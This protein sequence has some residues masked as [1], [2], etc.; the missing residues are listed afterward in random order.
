MIR[1]ILRNPESLTQLL[2]VFGGFP[3]VGAFPSLFR[4]Q[5][6]NDNIIEVDYVKKLTPPFQ[7]QED[8]DDDDSHDDDSDSH[9]EE[10]DAAE[11][12][13]E[14]ANGNDKTPKQDSGD[15]DGNDKASKQDSGDGGNDNDSDYS[16]EPP[17][18]DG[19]GGGILGLLAG[20]S[21][22]VSEINKK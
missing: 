13:I 2:G 9:S 22:G 11:E 21:G 20:L 12:S 6:I 8:D 17:E 18:G 14:T 5:D 19:Q 7:R 15:G 10:N 1:R 4:R 3:P 16:D